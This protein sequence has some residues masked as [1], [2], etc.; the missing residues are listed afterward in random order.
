[1]MDLR[2]VTSTQR[3]EERALESERR[4]GEREPRLQADDEGTVSQRLV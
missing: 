4:H 2:R 1:M 3:C